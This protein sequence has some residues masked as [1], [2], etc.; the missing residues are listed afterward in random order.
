[1]SGIQLYAKGGKKFMNAYKINGIPRFILL[2][3]KGNIVS[4]KVSRPSSEKLK[5]LFN[6]LKR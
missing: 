1:M 2:D 5:V 3:P 6:E 4:A